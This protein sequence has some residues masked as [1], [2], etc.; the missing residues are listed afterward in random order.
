MKMFTVPAWRFYAYLFVDNLR[1]A[2]VA[3]GK[4]FAT[5]PTRRIPVE[6]G[7][8]SGRISARSISSPREPIATVTTEEFNRVMM[9]NALDPMRAVEA[10]A[11]LVSPNGVIGVM[12]SGLGSIADN[13]VPRMFELRHEE[14]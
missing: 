12:S 1:H 3:K 11:D 10:L 6:P 8:A 9:T 7:R 13:E 4:A 2:P 5:Q 14:I